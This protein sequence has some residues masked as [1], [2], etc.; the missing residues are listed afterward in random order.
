MA[1]RNLSPEN[2]HRGFIFGGAAAVALRILFTALAVVPLNVPLLHAFGGVL[3]L[4]TAGKLLM[5][6]AVEH[7]VQEAGSLREA[8]QTIVLADVVMNLDNILAVSGPH[9]ATFAACCLDWPCRFQFCYSAPSWWRGCSAGS[10]NWS[11][12]AASC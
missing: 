5:P 4:F 6:E 1:A 8:T 7:E 3:P 10:P 11:P 2:R 9:T 12:L